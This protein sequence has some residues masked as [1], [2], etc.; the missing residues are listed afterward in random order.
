MRALRTEILEDVA[1]ITQ[2]LQKCYMPKF[3]ELANDANFPSNINDLLF[4]KEFSYLGLPEISADLAMCLLL[5]KT[6]KREINTETTCRP[7]TTTVYT[8]KSAI[9]L[10]RRARL[11]VLDNPLSLSKIKVY[12]QG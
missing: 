5:L 12:I 4:T 1:K 8:Y 3:K 6:K 9:L 2:V 11:H 10:D 7:F